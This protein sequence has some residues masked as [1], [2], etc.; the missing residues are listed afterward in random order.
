LYSRFSIGWHII[1][2]K[3]GDFYFHN[4]GTGGYTSSM[5]MDMQRKKGVVILSNISAF[6]SKMTYLD[7]L[8]FELLRQ[9]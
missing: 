3:T 5:L 1:Q 4:G 6:H 8:C 2:N 7:T 9:L